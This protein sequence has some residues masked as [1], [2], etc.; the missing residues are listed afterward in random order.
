M[1]EEP[2]QDQWMMFAPEIDITVTELAMIFRA[3]NIGVK[4]NILDR[5]P[6]SAQRHFKK[7]ELEYPE[8]EKD[9]E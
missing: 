3:M 8:K 5:M 2:E 6:K 4:K 9:D 7:R 1:S